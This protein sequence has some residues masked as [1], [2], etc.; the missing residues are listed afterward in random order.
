MLSATVFAV[1]GYMLYRIG[2]LRASG[3]VKLQSK[4]LSFV[5]SGTGPG[6][7]FMAFGATVLVAG[8]ISGGAGAQSGP[9][10]PVAD[11]KA[12]GGARWLYSVP[13]DECSRLVNSPDS[14]LPGALRPASVQWGPR[15]AA[16]IEDVRVL[17]TVVEALCTG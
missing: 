5:L 6:I 16:R 11:Q 10:G 3:S 13:A 9:S 8:L 7:V 17:R 4:F 15:L 12:G 14:A 2:L 1:L